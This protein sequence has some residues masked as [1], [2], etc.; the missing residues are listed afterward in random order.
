[1]N[2][3]PIHNFLRSL[4]MPLPEI[5][6]ALP[7]NGKIYD[8][9]CGEGVVSR[10]LAKN[11]KRKIVGVDI[12]GKRLDKN[13]TENLRFEQADIRNYRINN[14]RGIVLTDVLHH[15][16]FK[17][18]DTVLKNISKNLKYGGVLVIKEIDTGENLRSRLSR[19]WDFV[20]Y[21]KEKV[22]F[23]SAKALSSKLENL[24]FDVT[25][26]RSAYFFPGSTTLFICK[27]C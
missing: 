6:R 14:A 5:D 21:P 2:L 11:S 13:K 25:I 26:K 9:G 16:N 7:G 8:F 4:M 17:D 10:F 12:N 1:M 24:G 23:T 3:A 18:Q 22:Y 15:I 19:F 27:K 20:F